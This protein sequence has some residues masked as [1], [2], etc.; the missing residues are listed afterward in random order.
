MRIFKTIK[1]VTL[2]IVTITTL[3][4]CNTENYMENWELIRGNGLPDKYYSYNDILFISGNLG[5]IIGSL[6]NDRVS[7][8]KNRTI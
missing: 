5:F 4:S 1:C 6:Q 7:I 3:V 8:P 2:I